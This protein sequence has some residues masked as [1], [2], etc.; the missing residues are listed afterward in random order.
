M[1][2]KEKNWPILVSAPKNYYLSI[3]LSSHL[4]YSTGWL[5]DPSWFRIFLMPA[6]Q[7]DE[8]SSWQEGGRE[9]QIFDV[10]FQGSLEEFGSIRIEYCNLEEKC[11]KSRNARQS[12]PL[13]RTLSGF[14][15]R[16]KICDKQWI[17]QV[18]QAVFSVLLLISVHQ[19][20]SL[21]HLPSFFKLYEFISYSIYMKNSKE[22]FAYTKFC[23]VKFPQIVTLVGSTNKMKICSMGGLVIVIY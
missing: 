6:T 14:I 22:C 3:R 2:L 20:N 7:T 17:W 4:L 1:I 18:K 9:R 5:P 10:A 11:S 12:S 16:G 15:M 23:F 13:T 19:A 8:P 21:R